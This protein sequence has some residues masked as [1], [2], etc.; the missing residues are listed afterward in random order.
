MVMASKF[1]TTPLPFDRRRSSDGLMDTAEDLVDKLD[2]LADI[3]EEL[4]EK[5]SKKDDDVEEG[6]C[7][8]R[9]LKEG[10]DSARSLI[11]C[12]KREKGR[13]NRRKMSVELSIGELED[14]KMHLKEDVTNLNDTM[15]ALSQRVVD[16]ENALCEG[17]EIQEEMEMEKTVLEKRLEDAE[18]KCRELENCKQIMIKELKSVRLQRSDSYLRQENEELRSELEMLKIEN[19]S[20]KNIIRSLEE[21]LH[22]PKQEQDGGADQGTEKMESKQKVSD[23]KVLPSATEEENKQPRES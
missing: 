20:L 13:I 6:P 5:Y 17:Q 14:Y 3:L 12:L 19:T 10:L 2:S 4:E 23:E 15:E 11:S 7:P 9:R 21:E 16:L 8:F 18:D 22:P 1:R